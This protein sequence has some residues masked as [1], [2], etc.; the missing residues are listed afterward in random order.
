MKGRNEMEPARSLEPRKFVA[1]VL[2]PLKLNW[3]VWKKC[4]SGY[5]ATGEKFNP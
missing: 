3:H 1:F 4:R 5:A 2:F